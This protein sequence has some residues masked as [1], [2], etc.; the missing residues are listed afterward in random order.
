MFSL[1]HQPTRLCDGLDRREW[2]RCGSIGLGSLSLSHLLQ[3]TTQAQSEVVHGPRFGQAKSVIAVCLLGG[4]G[5]HETWDPKPLA[6]PEVRGP[7]GLIDTAVRGIQ[8]SE[9][10]PQTARHTD[11]TAVLRATV[12]DDNAH[13]SSGYQ[14]L[15]GVPHIPMNVEN[16][17][18]K[19]PNRHPSFAAIVRHHR[20]IVNGLPGAIQLPQHIANVGDIHWPGQDAGWLG[21]PADPWLIECDTSIPDFKIPDLQLQNDLVDVRL[22]RRRSL[23]EQVDSHLA[24]VENAERLTGYGRQFEAAYGMLASPQARAA[25]DLSSEKAELRDRYGHTKFGQALLLSRRLVEA[26]VPLIQVNW[27]QL[28][29]EAPNNGS[30]DTHA[31]HARSMK[32]FLMPVMDRAFSTLLDDL[33]ERGM[34]ED[35]L[36]LWLGEFGRTPRFNGNGGRDHWGRCFSIAMAG[37]G[38]RG[39]QVFGQS[40]K[41]AAYPIADI[42]RPHDVTATMFHLLGLDPSTELQDPLNRPVPISRGRVIDELL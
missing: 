37:G 12:T 36:V 27:S 19:F 14:M 8:V 2:L 41:D 24:A 38:I 25:F 17:T 29:G 22:E 39:G 18:P 34:L 33:R 7:F 20:P 9:L 32:D 16:A 5:Q 35:T 40:D 4:P 26:G 10:M 31:Q 21:R 28:K 42:V 30:W 13:S 1:L 15:T 23:R 11:V 3:R 6:P